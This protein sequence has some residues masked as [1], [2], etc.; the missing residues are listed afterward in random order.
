MLAVPNG[1]LHGI[2]AS[3]IYGH[4]LFLPHQSGITCLLP[5]V[6]QFLLWWRTTQGLS[7]FPTERGILCTFSWL[8]T[9]AADTQSWFCL[10]F[11][12]RVIVCFEL[13]FTAMNRDGEICTWTV[14]ILYDSYVKKISHKLC[15]RRFCCRCTGVC[16]PPSSVILNF[17]KECIQLHLSRTINTVNRMLTSTAI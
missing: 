15:K 13:S 1:A 12:P 6:V 4:Q 7:L 8:Y 17:W 14:I 10:F 16:V 5:F 2:L 3:L 11:W 9:H